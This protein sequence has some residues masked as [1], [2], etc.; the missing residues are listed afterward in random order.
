MNVDVGIIGGGVAGSALAHVLSRAGVSV[1]LVEREAEFRDRIRGEA[2][3][4]WGTRE[5]DRLG[6]RSLIVSSAR[7]LE[8]PIWQTYRARVKLDPIVWTNLHASIPP[9]LSVRH[10]ELQNALIEAAG[11]S[12]AHVFRPATVEL[13]RD[14]RGPVM[15]VQQD[16]TTTTVSARLIVGADGSHSATRSWLGGEATR[17]PTHHY[18]A[19]TLVS[20]LNLDPNAAH[21]AS[22][23]GGFSM[24]FPQTGGSFRLYFVCLPEEREGLKGA[25]QPQAILDGAARYFPDGLVGD[26]KPLGPT[27]FFPNADVVS[28]IYSGRDAVLIGDAAGANDPSL[29]HG[30]ALVFRDVRELSDLLTQHEDWSDIPAEF[31]SRR[32]TYYN[33]LREH[34]KW[35]AAITTE[36]GPEADALR[37]QVARA[38]EADPTAGGFAGL[39]ALGPDRLVADE[40][41]RRHFLGYDL[42]S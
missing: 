39:F 13:G 17:D 42:A 27:G 18:L 19:G 40:A 5:V 37:A 20:G 23:P 25:N 2:I 15:T 11:E 8:L 3:H 22:A 7:G 33:V 29:G 10:V 12:G 21:H 38:R 24:I 41:A 35:V 9:V 14:A 36:I 4:P 31:G 6:L 34:A 32:A 16:G 30:L 28:S 1:A 26:W